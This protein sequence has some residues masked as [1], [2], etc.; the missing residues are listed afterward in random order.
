MTGYS[1]RTCAEE[2]ATSD[3]F[4]RKLESGKRYAEITG[5]DAS[6]VITRFFS[7][8]YMFYQSTQVWGNLLSSAVLSINAE[9]KSNKSDEHL[10]LCG[11]NF[12]LNN[13]D[14][15]ESFTDGN[16]TQDISSQLPKPANWQIYVLAT[17][18]L[19]APALA[20]LLLMTF[21]DP[22]K[23][24]QENTME[25]KSDCQLV[26]ATF[27]HL[28]HPYQML[29]VPLTIWSGIERAFLGADFTAA[30]VSC[31]LGIH[32]V[33]FIMICYGAF[34]VLASMSASTMVRVLGRVPLIIL[35]FLINLSMIITLIYWTPNPQQMPVF[36]AISGLWGLADGI[37]QTQIN[38]L[39]GVLFAGNTE[40]GFS[41]C[42]LWGATGFSIAFACSSVLCVHSK[43]IVIITILVLG[44]TGYLIIEVIEKLG[45]LYKRS[46]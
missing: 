46:D 33:G 2:R 13:R 7:I 10:D 45:G 1:P 32:M 21:L 39:Y 42:R 37:W 16:G 44:V 27:D 31:S 36:F 29:L 34:G 41:N 20:T 18:Y 22:I 17:V 19:A 12:C 4:L 9:I 26:A 40:A 6:V 15:N 24:S 23:G 14:Q 8:F 28:R 11:Y 35:A 3:E 38:S 25:G 30:Y 43:I 5:E